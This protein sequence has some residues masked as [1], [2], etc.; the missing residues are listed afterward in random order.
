MVCG[1]MLLGEATAECVFAPQDSSP[2]ARI[3][4]ILDG[5]P[6]QGAKLD[7]YS[8]ATQTHFSEM[9][10]ESGAVMPPK[11]APGTYEV[12]A[13]LNEVVGISLDLVVA[14][15]PGVTDLAM[16]LTDAVQKVESIPVASQLQTFQ[17]NVQD[18]SGAAVP[19]ARIVI[20][21]RG[22]RTKKLVLDTKSDEQGHFSK[23]LPAGSYIAFFL[24]PGFQTEVIPFEVASTGTG[25]LKPKLKPGS[26]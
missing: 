12:K 23:E 16:D 18:V 5:K 25:D 21:T 6:L 26:C 14:E 17:G 9:T 8:D 19:A 3:T 13:S 20:V 15:R 22:S 2:Q 1:A 11:L 24:S 10:D 4:V 7:F